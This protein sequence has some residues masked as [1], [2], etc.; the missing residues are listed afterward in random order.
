MLDANLHEE[1]IKDIILATQESKAL[2]LVFE[3]VSVAKSLRILKINELHK[4]FLIKPNL[5]ELY[6]MTNYIRAKNGKSELAY[7]ESILLNDDISN[8]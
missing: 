5:Q 6:T 2:H 1:F 3:P 7:S 8:N 4:F